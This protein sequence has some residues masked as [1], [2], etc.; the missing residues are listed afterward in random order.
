MKVRYHSSLDPSSKHL[1]GY[2]VKSL[3]T[4]ESFSLTFKCFRGSANGVYDSYARLETTFVF[5]CR[6]QSVCVVC[7][8]F[9][10]GRVCLCISYH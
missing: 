9:V 7:L 8:L 1:Y 6:F 4:S 5:I 3:I 2:P 10:L